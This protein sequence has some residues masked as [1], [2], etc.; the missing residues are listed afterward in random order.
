MTRDPLHHICMTVRAKVRNG[1]IEM[2]AGAALP[3]GADV[4]VHLVAPAVDE[5]TAGQQYQAGT[6]AEALL[7]FAGAIDTLPPDFSEHF[8]E[9]RRGLRKR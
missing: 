9:Y 7:E 4:E 8:D 6:A 2:P 5:P 1:A 3:E